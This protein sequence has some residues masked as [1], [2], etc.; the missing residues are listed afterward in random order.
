[1][2][3]GFVYIWFDKKHKRYYIGSHWGREDDGYICSSRWMRNAYK[4]RP[5]DFKRRILSRVV[6]TRGDLLSEEHRW[7][8]KISKEDLGNKYYNLTNHLNGHWSSDEQ[9]TKTLKQKLSEKAR[10][11]HNNP[12]WR[13]K[14]EAG[15]KQRD[16]KSSDPS[17]KEKRRQSMLGKN[18]GKPK[19]QTFYDAMAK[20]R[21]SNISEEHKQKIRTAGT[22]AKLNN[23]RVICPHCGTEGNPGTIARYHVDNCKQRVS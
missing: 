16:N 3:R 8:Q 20:K 11:N 13:A 2:K 22:F 10:E 4:R 1:M 23:K 6:S 5:W 17:V 21:G 15:L 19:T 14:Y 7:L 9:K 18:V 12:Q